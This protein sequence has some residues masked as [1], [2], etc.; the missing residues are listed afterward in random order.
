[1]GKI[2]ILTGAVITAAGVLTAVFTLLGM[3]E[4]NLRIENPQIEPGRYRF[5][6]KEVAA[7]HIR[8]TIRKTWGVSA[9]VCRSYVNDSPEEN[10]FSV[11]RF[12]SATL[13]GM[14]IPNSYLRR[15]GNR[16]VV[17][18]DKTISNTLTF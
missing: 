13:H 12:W 17:Y 3:G 9:N 11:G 8:M 1:M 18:C 15:S 16:I 5:E 10:F 2:G 7:I 14:V 6:G 4:L